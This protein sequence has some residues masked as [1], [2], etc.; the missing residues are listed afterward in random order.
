LVEKFLFIKIIPDKSHQSAK[1]TYSIK[2]YPHKNR[3]NSFQ[4]E[5]W[6][7][8][9]LFKTVRKIQHKYLEE[10][11]LESFF[12]HSK[13]FEEGKLLYFFV[14]NIRI[15]IVE[16]AYSTFTFAYTLSSLPLN[17]GKFNLG[18]TQEKIMKK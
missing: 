4:H 17:K 15:K 12:W 9:L 13:R 2:S 14:S 16:S 5:T 11:A 1:K 7:F 8:R 3:V 10:K 18:H 6:C